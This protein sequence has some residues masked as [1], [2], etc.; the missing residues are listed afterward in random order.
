[1]TYAESRDFNEFLA[2]LPHRELQND[3]YYYHF[4]RRSA[5]TGRFPGSFGAK[6]LAD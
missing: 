4:E 2:L 1:M 6:K 3:H 5:S